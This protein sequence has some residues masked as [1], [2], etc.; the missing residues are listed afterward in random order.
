MAETPGGGGG[1]RVVFNLAKIRGKFIR[2]SYKKLILINNSTVTI[3]DIL[4]G[5]ERQ[6]V[7]NVFLLLH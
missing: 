3:E 6:E 2:L 5:Y 4:K 1:G 7:R